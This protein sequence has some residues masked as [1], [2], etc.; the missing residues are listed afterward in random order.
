RPPTGD[1]VD[2]TSV[3]A[4]KVRVKIHFKEEIIV[5]KLPPMT[6]YEGLVRTIQQNISPR[7]EDEPL[8]IKYK[9]RDGDM[10][11]MRNNEDVQMAFDDQPG[12]QVVLYV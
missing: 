9:D 10:V 4:R 11:S 1:C 2:L 6:E 12:G 3:N 5:L 7:C 8:E